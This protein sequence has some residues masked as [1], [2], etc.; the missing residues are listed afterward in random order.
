MSTVASSRQQPLLLTG[1]AALMT[2][3]STVTP[4]MLVMF[5]AGVLIY[6]RS[7]KNEPSLLLPI[8]FARCLV[9]CPTRRSIIPAAC[10]T[11]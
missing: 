6:L 1:F 7:S 9:T 4:G 11:S 3:F 5:M 8:G 2:L 10:C